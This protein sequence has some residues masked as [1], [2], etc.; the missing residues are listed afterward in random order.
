MIF[1]EN[2]FKY[3]TQSEMI[4]SSQSFNVFLSTVDREHIFFEVKACSDVWISLSTY[5]VS[6]FSNQHYL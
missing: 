2:A 3:Y 4:S 5:P 1:S 6:Y